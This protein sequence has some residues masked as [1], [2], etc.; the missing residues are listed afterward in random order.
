MYLAHKTHKTKQNQTETNRNRHE[1]VTQQRN[2]RGWELPKKG[3]RMPRCGG[4]RVGTGMQK[5]EIG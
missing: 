4:W 1:S 2:R 5:T 3:G